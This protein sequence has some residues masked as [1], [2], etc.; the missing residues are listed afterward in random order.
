LNDHTDEEEFD[1]QKSNNINEKHPSENDLL[2]ESFNNN[3][4]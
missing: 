4:V 3:F 2:L 1:R